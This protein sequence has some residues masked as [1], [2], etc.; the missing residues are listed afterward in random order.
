MILGVELVGIE[1]DPAVVALGAITGM[2]YGILAVGL[3]LVFRANRII[4]FAHGD[5]G[6]FG[7]ALLGVAVVDWG[8]PY[9]MAFVLACAAAAGVGAASEVVIVRRLRSAPVLMSVIATLGLGQFLT[10]FSAAINPSGRAGN[11]FPQPP[12]LPTFHIGELPIT[13]AYSAMLFVTPLLVV[14]LVVFLRR[15]SIGIAIRASADNPD[16]AQMS[17]ILTNRMSG[18]TWAIAGGVAAYTAILVLPTRGFTATQFLGPGLL[19]R[20]LTCA[21]L[22]RM[23]RLDLALAT[24]VGLGILEQLIIANN[25]T[26]GIVEIALFGIVLAALLSQRARTGRSEPK[27]SWASVQAG[28]PLPRALRELP[29]FRHGFWVALAAGAALAVAL[30]LTVTNATAVTLIV[31]AAFTT[32]GLSIGIVTGLSGQLSLGQF[33]LAGVGATAA[34]VAG[35][36]GVGFAP[37]LV[38]AGLAAAAVSLVIALPALRIRGLMAA[39]TTLAF[40]LAAQLWLLQQSWMLGRG[41]SL[42][43]PS[44]LGIDFGLDRNYFLVAAAV[45]LGAFWLAHNVWTG[46]TGRRLRA[47]RD[48]EDAAR[49]FTVSPT[50]AKVQAFALGGFLAGLGGAVYGHMLSQTASSAFPI[51]SSI[52][53][54]AV[55][56][57]GGIGT[58]VGPLLGALYIIGIPAFLPLD[59][60]GLAATSFGWL[61]LIVSAPGGIAQALGPVRARVIRAFASLV[62]ARAENGARTV[63][64]P[65]ERGMSL[66]AAPRVRVDAGS[67]L[68]EAHRLSKRFGGIAAVRD[69]DL[70]VRAGETVGLIGPNGAGKTT[71]F[72]LL[73]GFTPADDGTVVFAG[74]DVSAASPEA[75]AKLGLARSFQDAALFPTMTVAEV[76]AVASE[77]VAPT[78]FAADVLGLRAADHRKRAHADELVHAMGLEDFRETPVRA[79]S[80]GTR[81]IT[82]LA[83]LIALEPTL[84]LLDEPT[85]GIAQREA[86]ALGGLLRQM[87]AELGLTLVIIE[88]DIP[89]VM[90]LA[91]RIV[92]MESGAVIADGTPAAVRTDPRVITSY[93]GG[94]VRAIE[95]SDAQGHDEERAGVAR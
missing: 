10:V 7:G 37:A 63:T 68:L 94:D 6:A 15:G 89:L 77:R 47:V 48:N 33:A 55:A 52:N 65:H 64:D 66:T 53:A 50:G 80:T 57:V 3:V 5:I 67:V 73:S 60:A 86:E 38:F 69:V 54:A 43:R 92:A 36:H 90:G 84:L 34:Y 32:V 4:N 31:I 95:R 82:E 45:M 93:L 25:P 39:V 18:L 21:V 72:E 27:G 70:S 85:S 56:V 23:T 79:L 74:Q 41:V 17:G 51:D 58:L 9:W 28:T 16:A 26:G 42:G 14:V 75:R 1:I 83:C 24:G 81:R 20:A 35:D 44:F 49:A 76:V 88:H 8:L 13:R 46:G 78:K 11:V 87:Q 59:N 91:D 22:A 30:S 12:G 61:A 62:D 2:I 19:L 71:L 40:A 29:L